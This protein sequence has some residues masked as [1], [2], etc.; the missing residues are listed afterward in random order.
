MYQNQ[1]EY[2]TLESSNTYIHGYTCIKIK[3]NTYYIITLIIMKR[4]RIIRTHKYT[5]NIRVYY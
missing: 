1:M 4:I 2:S 3:W 5:T